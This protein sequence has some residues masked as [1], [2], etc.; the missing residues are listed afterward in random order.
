M[1]ITMSHISYVGLDSYRQA[2]KIP[3]V[4]CWNRTYVL[5]VQFTYRSVMGLISSCKRIRACVAFTLAA[6][7]YRKAA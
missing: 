4:H 7:K 6:T 1:R 5:S 3:M 2:L